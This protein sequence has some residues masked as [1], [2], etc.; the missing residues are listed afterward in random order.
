MKKYTN[1]LIMQ[2]FNNKFFRHLRSRK[3]ITQRN[4][5]LA[6]GFRIVYNTQ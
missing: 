1:E 2:Q 6:S 5:T 3:Y 4:I